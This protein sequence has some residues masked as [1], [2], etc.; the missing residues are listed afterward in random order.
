M[1]TQEIRIIA[2]LTLEVPVELSKSELIEKFSNKMVEI[3]V[4]EGAVPKHYISSLE[5]IDIE[6]EAQIYGND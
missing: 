3:S 4:V 1:T 5:I 6:E 2:Q